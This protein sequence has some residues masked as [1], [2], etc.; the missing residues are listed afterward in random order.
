MEKRS[1]EK[2]EG[3]VEKKD[4]IFRADKI[5]LKSL[6]KQLEKHLSRVWSRNLEVN[7]K[8]YKEE[9]EIDLAKLETSNVIAHGTYGIVY[10]GKYDGQAVAGRF[11]ILWFYISPEKVEMFITIF[12][13]RDCDCVLVVVFAVK[14]LDWEDNGN[15]TAAKTDANRT[16]FRQE[17]TVWHKL[18]HPN[19]TK[20]S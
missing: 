1:G 3:G 18:D 11:I 6:D 15:E 8:A 20:V 16:L 7:H 9:W 19:V 5:D 10:Q 14:V 13:F 12:P 17:V 2:E 4:K